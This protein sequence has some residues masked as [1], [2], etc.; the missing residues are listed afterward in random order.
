MHYKTANKWLEVLNR[1][2]REL[3]GMIDINLHI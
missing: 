1:Q 2:K 3:E